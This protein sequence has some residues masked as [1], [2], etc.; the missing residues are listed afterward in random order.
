[1]PQENLPLSLFE[2]HRE[3]LNLNDPLIITDESALFQKLPA[4]A[5]SAVVF[6]P[7][8]KA[9]IDM[10]LSLVSG[11]VI[12]GG[13]IV[14]A[15]ANDAGI[16]SAKDAYE[17][18]IGP[19][20]EKIVGNH[21]ALY[22]G[23]NERRGA[24]KTIEDFLAFAPI[25]FDGM[26]IEAASV[27]GVFSAGELDAG[28]KLLLEHVPY[29]K[30]SVLDMA[31]GAGTIGAFYIKKNPGATVTLSDASPLAVLATKKTLEKNNM[32]G[33]VVESDAFERITGKFDL[34][35]CNPPFHKG[36]GT[37]YS[38]IEKFAAQAR[39]YL[40]PNGQVFVVANAFLAYQDILSKIGP[41]EIVADDRK[42]RVYRSTI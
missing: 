4:L 36:V 8:S 38:F 18:N 19:V 37:D 3:A 17:K 6:L 27:P 9:L 35:L 16:R 11:M 42:F 15:G 30:K 28:T 29:D 25:E 2:K 22:V 5:Q 12:Q 32:S 10:T 7:K 31:C 1:M 14:L 39:K 23:T 24:G 13:T 41:T 34:I 33:S 21:S 26:T 20:R 40:N